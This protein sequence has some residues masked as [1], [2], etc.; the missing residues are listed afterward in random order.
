MR[1][2]QDRRQLVRLWRITYQYLADSQRPENNN[3]Y[4]LA[5]AAAEAF[6]IWCHFL[7]GEDVI[8]VAHK[9]RVMSLE[10]G[11]DA[12]L[13][14]FW[15]CDGINRVE[16]VDLARPE[17]ARTCAG[18]TIAWTLISFPTYLNKYP[19]K[20]YFSVTVE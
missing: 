2:L 11:S 18:R 1:V 16:V 20:E 15:L 12:H 5:V 7:N 6:L 10:P 8:C 9:G 19:Q 13:K 17:K 4:K 14:A 3:T